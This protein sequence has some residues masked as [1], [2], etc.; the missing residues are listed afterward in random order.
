VEVP[1]F[2]DTN[3]G[4]LVLFSLATKILQK[5]WVVSLGCFDNILVQQLQE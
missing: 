1:T 4:L 2:N 3:K 5:L